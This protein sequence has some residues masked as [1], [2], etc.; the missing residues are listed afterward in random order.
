MN[1][2]IEVT[3]GSLVECNHSVHIAVVNSEG[4]LIYSYGDPKKVIYARSSVK[5]IQAIQVLET[6][7]DKAYDITDREISFMCSSH[8]GEPYHVDCTRQILKKADISVDKLN[9]GTHVPGNSQI[10]KELIESKEPLTQEHN[11]C[12]GKHS[13]ML[14]SAKNL[15]EDLD[16]YLDINHPVQQRILENI[17]YVCNYEKEKIIIGIDGCG[18]P[19]HAMPLERFAYGFARL[20]DPS[21]LEEKEVYAQKITSA[22]MKYPEMVAGRDR[23]CTALMRVCG[24]RIFG[25]AGAQ[26][27]YLVGDK[28]NN[29]GIAVK[30]E[31]GSGQATACATMEVLNQLDLIT[32]EELKELENFANPKLLNARKD[33]IGQ[34]RPSFQLNN[35][36]KVEG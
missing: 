30:V 14:I 19:V 36:I 18:A 7:A 16:T 20:A 1:K 9:C 33:V 28:N 10:Y 6:K 15:N 8:S 26:G 21:K 25:K 11:N 3:R 17:A 4:E 31:D 27:V 32:K 13:G 29:L 34:M 2:A 5:P 12:S 23:F 35:L 22:M 24:D